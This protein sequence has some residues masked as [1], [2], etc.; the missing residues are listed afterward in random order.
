VRLVST[1]N[2]SFPGYKTGGGLCAVMDVAPAVSGLCQVT[3]EVTRDASSTCPVSLVV[4]G[5]TGS[6]TFTPGRNQVASCASV[7]MPASG[8]VD[9][10]TIQVRGVS[11]L[12]DATRNPAGLT[13]CSMICNQRYFVA[14][15]PS[16]T[17]GRFQIRY[18]L[19]QARV[20]TD[21]VTQVAATKTAVP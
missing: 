17:L 3:E 1:T 7:A 8:F 13:S 11:V 19:T 2:L 16:A 4:G 15:N 12:H 20:G 6:S 21:D 5:C 18:D 9:R 10:H 14:G